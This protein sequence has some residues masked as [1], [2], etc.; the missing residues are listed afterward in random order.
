MVR[1]FR[2][3]DILNLSYTLDNYSV[4]PEVVYS[5]T[6]AKL[7]LGFELNEEDLEELRFAKFLS[8]KQNK[9]EVTDLL[10]S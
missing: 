10:N 6:Q 7:E 3:K 2:I 8:E 4:V 1:F 5:K 9:K